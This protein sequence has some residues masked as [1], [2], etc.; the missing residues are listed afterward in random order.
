MTHI[1]EK[2][3]FIITA[4]WSVGGIRLSEEQ[5]TLH[6]AKR[7]DEVLD[8]GVHGGLGDGADD[9]LELKNSCCGVCSVVWSQASL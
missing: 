1:I 7:D 9:E 8:A 4:L 2:V 6:D 5:N 3:V